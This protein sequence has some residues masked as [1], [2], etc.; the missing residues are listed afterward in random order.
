MPIH[1]EDLEIRQTEHKGRGVFARGFIARGTLVTPLAGAIATTADLP[2]D[3]LA[4]QIDDDLWLYSD[5]T[6]LDDCINHSCE[7]NLG[8]TQGD[9]NL[10]ALRD[11]EAGEELSWDYSTSIAVEDWRLECRCAT[12][13]CRGTILPWQELRQPD[14]DRL[15]PLA[16]SFLRRRH[17]SSAERE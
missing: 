7:P 8:F 17:E 15:R 9:L 14:R 6:S 1:P 10:Y 16:L 13:G 4:L 5:G 11:I 12:E 3:S 2:E